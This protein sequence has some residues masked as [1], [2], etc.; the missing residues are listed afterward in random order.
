LEH[1]RVDFQTF[2]ELLLNQAGFRE[3]K[4]PFFH[5]DQGSGGVPAI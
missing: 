5:V 4:I 1:S 3:I 2:D